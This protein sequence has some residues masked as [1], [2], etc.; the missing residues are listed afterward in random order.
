MRPIPLRDRSSFIQS[1]KCERLPSTRRVPRADTALM[2]QSFVPVFERILCSASAR[3]KRQQ[4][5]QQGCHLSGSQRPVGKLCRRR[6]DGGRSGL[7]TF[8]Q[9]HRRLGAT[10]LCP[11]DLQRLRTLLLSSSSS[12]AAQLWAS[13]FADSLV[14][15][16]SC[17]PPVLPARDKPHKTCDA[18]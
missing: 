14:L 11:Y 15:P 3:L 18:S 10:C 16:S 5:L 9:R 8:Q 17:R 13:V 7:F 4:H 2:R 12:V 1:D 6:S